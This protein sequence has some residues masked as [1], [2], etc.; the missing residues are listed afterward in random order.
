M[1]HLFLA[2]GLLLALTAC[3]TGAPPAGSPKLAT[4]TN[5]PVLGGTSW[6]VSAIHGAATLPDR[7]PT[8]TFDADQVSGLA[9]CNRFFGAYTQDGETLKFDALAATQMMCGEP[10]V[11]EQEA[12]MLSAAESAVKVQ[13]TDTGL[14]LLDANG[15]TVLTL[16]A[17]QDLPLEDTNWQLTSIITNDAATSALADGPVSMKIEGAEL[18]GKACNVF[19]ASL[20]SGPDGDFKVGPVRSTRMACQTEELSA[21]EH[22]VLTLLE[23]VTSYKISGS[24]L[25][26]KAPDGSGLEFLAN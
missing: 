1:K 17:V 4:D 10:G 7:Q 6:T 24:A 21:Q 26:L 15:E 19:S 9:S 13:A 16:V 23:K 14:E 11:M 18:S 8:M 5:I 3:A 22:T 2:L 20:T 25:S 12:K